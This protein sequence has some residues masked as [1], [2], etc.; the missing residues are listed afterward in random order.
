VKFVF[1]H[2]ADVAYADQAAAAMTGVTV[3][4]R[5]LVPLGRMYLIAGEQTAEI[6]QAAE[7]EQLAE[8]ILTIEPPSRPDRGEPR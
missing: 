1:A 4:L 6:R 2:P 8:E 7:L 3:K 5:R